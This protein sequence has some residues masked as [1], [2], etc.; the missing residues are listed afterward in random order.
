MSHEHDDTLPR[1]ELA[2]RLEAWARGLRAGRLEVEGKTWSVPEIVSAELSIHEKKGSLGLK[3][4]C[5]WATLPEYRPEAR[6]PVA[7]WQE[8]FKTLKKRMAGQFRGLQQ[9]VSQGQFPDSQT[10]ADFVSD[11]QAMAKM[12]EPEWGEALESYL[13][14][15]AALERAV[16]GQ[17]LTAAKHEI[18]DLHTAMVTCHREFK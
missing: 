9:A 8:S 2:D 16:A 5:R 18:G 4:K 6:E 1:Q 3:L 17:D 12:A 7:R 15:L 10:L 13:A 14:H 11:S